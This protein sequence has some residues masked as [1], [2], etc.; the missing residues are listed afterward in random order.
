MQPPPEVL[1]YYEEFP[2]ESRLGVGPFRLEFE[3][4][5]DIL[6]RVLP[7][8]PARVVDVGGAA[9]AYSTWLAELGYDV[10][11]VDVSPRLVEEARRRNAVA[12]RPVASLAVAD[13][14]T[15]P[16]PDASADCVLL[17][18]P[19]YHLP[20]AADRGRALHEA[21][22]VLVPSGTVAWM[23]RGFSRRKSRSSA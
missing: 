19:L 12:S 13:A 1:R 14:R 23:R 18:G 22:R 11:L 17:M 8:P 6:S 4:T 5:K 20:S 21:C 10:H 15:L 2:E 16:E 9:G 3:R 7:P